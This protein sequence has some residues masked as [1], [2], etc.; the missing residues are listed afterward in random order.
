MNLLQ[1][2]V[3]HILTS[4]SFSFVLYSYG[5]PCFP[6]PAMVAFQFLKGCEAQLGMQIGFIVQLKSN[7][8]AN[9]KIAVKK[10]Y[11]ERTRPYRLKAAIHKQFYIMMSEN[12]HFHFDI[13]GQEGPV[14]AQGG[15]LMQERFCDFLIILGF[16]H[17]VH[18]G[19][20]N[21]VL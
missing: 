5:S 19:K 10:N 1:N 21:L 13:N 6:Q 7:L 17:S 9:S 16:Y 2:S 3:D 20:K 18:F 4:P 12:L 11:Y 14:K 8:L 15:F